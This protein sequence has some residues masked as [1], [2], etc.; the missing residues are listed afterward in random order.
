MERKPEKTS[1]AEEW[2]IGM[3]EL[4]ESQKETDRLIKE[5]SKNI[6]GISNSNGSF[7]EEYFL[8]SLCR[9]MEFAGIHF[10]KVTGGGQYGGKIEMPDGSV[11]EDEF[12]IVMLNGNSVAIIEIKYKAKS[13]DVEDLANR[14]VNDFR[15]L[16]PA[17]K[18]FNIYLGLG[19]LSFDNYV[20]NKAKEC[21]VGLLKQIGETVESETKWIR[22]Y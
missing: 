19:S 17:Y 2:R 7:A 9:K 15:I 18:N 8:N 10:N 1:W 22:A 12:D 20:V 3:Q 21:G 11:R 6:G 14:K 13:S 4:R 16:N 5:L